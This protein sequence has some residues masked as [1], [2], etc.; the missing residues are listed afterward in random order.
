VA[1]SDTHWT[2]A[3]VLHLETPSEV[4]LPQ[5]ISPR[6]EQSLSATQSDRL[7]RLYGLKKRTKNLKGG[8][9]ATLLVPLARSGRVTW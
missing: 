3:A 1:H 7:S 4:R 9:A 8:R 5:G 2:L 6:S